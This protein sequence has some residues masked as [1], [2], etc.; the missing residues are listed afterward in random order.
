MAPASPASRRAAIRL[1]G[2]AV[3]VP[4]R[5]K[6][7]PFCVVD[8]QDGRV[9]EF[10]GD[11]ADGLQLAYCITIHKAQ[12]SEYPVVVIPLT[13]DAEGLPIG[14]QL[15]GRRWQD[16][17]LLAIAAQIARLTDGFQRPPGF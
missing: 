14:A 2:R 9:V 6:A 4:A 11:D 16:E 13:R 8:F 7:V 15:I 5:P 10:T 3:P 12:G 1:S 17:R